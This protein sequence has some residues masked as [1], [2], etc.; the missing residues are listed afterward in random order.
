MLTLSFAYAILAI[1]ALFSCD[2]KA[3]PRS[4]TIVLS[5]SLKLA[6]QATMAYGHSVAACTKPS[7]YRVHSCKNAL[8]TMGKKR[9]AMRQAWQDYKQLSASLV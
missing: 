8:I 4:Q 1:L 6:R 7:Y 9:L 5:T 2:R 3:A